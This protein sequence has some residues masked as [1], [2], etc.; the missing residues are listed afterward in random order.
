M[1]G[2]GYATSTPGAGDPAPP[3]LHHSP[4]YDRGTVLYT[5]PIAPGDSA[6]R[7]P[8]WAP[9]AVP[10][11]P[12]SPGTFVPLDADR[13]AHAAPYNFAAPA[14]MPGVAEEFIARF[15][16]AGLTRYDKRGFGPDHQGDPAAFGY[17]IGLQMQQ[18]IYSWKEGPLKNVVILQY[19]IINAGTDTLRDCIASQIWDPELGQRN[20]DRGDFYVRRPELRTAF[21]WTEAEAGAIGPY[22]VLTTTML[23]APIVDANGFVAN[24]CRAGFRADGRVAVFKNTEI[25]EAPFYPASRYTFLSDEMIDRD[26]GADDRYGLLASKT[27][28]MR[29]G[30]TAYFAIGFAVLDIP[31][32]SL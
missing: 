29:P 24:R 32:E 11:R 8:L 27:F 7:W 16:D 25:T 10:V 1:P 31:P 4:G 9:A 6:Y 22:G 21:N 26:R 28:S 17:P 19:T 20:N 30:D 18:N 12:M 23:E 15:H 13:A 2:E 14:F 3:I 5:G